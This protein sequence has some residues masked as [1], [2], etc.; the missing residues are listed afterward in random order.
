MRIAIVSGD[1]IVGDDPQQ[2]SAALAARGHEVTGFVRRP[3]RRHAETSNGH[4]TVPV[5]VGPPTATSA[6]E[7]LPYVGDWAGALAREWTAERPDVVHAYGWLGGLAAQLAARRQ[8]VPTVQ[9]FLGLAASCKPRG[10]AVEPTDSERLRIEPLLAR[11]ATWVTGESGDDV[12]ALSRLRRSRA[13]V[14]ALTSGV[15]VERY[16]S[17]GPALARTDLHRVLCLAPNP[18]PCNGLDIAIK[19]LPRIPAT[20]LVIA[21]TEATEPD[22]NEARA[23]LQQQ[24]AKLGVAERVRFAGTVVGDELPMLLRSADVVACTPRQPPRA[25]TVLQAMASGV[26]VVAFGVGVLKDAVVDNVTGLVL[27]SQTSGGL[28]AALR[29]LLAQSFQCES[30][31]AAGRSRALSRYAWDRIA[32]DSQN[33][34]QQVGAP[35][36]AP[37][38]LQS[39]G[40]R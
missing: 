19:A 13:R 33:I 25:T 14:S 34:Y 17:R 4:R 24:A 32:L 23:G 27:S 26:V 36:L 9:S 12:D 2:L 37:R 3:G 7:V 28:S 30:M 29:N 40:V 8:A 16:N 11:S 35:C 38:R 20:E 39:S 31:G 6:A 1:D 10:A 21:E 15:D 5:P 22:H 18:M